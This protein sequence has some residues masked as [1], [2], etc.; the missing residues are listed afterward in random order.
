MTHSRRRYNDPGTRVRGN[1]VRRSL[2]EFGITPGRFVSSTRES[3]GVIPQ[4]FSLAFIPG[5]DLLRAD[6][7][8]PPDRPAQDQRGTPPTSTGRSPAT[9]LPPDSIRTTEPPTR[10][11]T[12]VVTESTSNTATVQDVLLRPY[13][14][15]FS[16]PT[17]LLQVSAHLKQTLKISVVLDIAA[18]ARQEVDPDDK[19]QLELRRPAQDGTEV[20]ARSA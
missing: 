9:G 12:P 16:R 6:R 19:V 5:R 13:H 10:P 1:P 20:A 18:L 2:S 7:L 11:T 15:P 3:R 14:F 4:E 8:Q 17:S